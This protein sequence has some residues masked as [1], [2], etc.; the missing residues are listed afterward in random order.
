M[1]TFDWKKINDMAAKAA[2]GQA[3]TQQ[4][5]AA[6]VG[7]PGAAAPAAPAA[8]TSP[9]TPAAPTTPV[10]PPEQRVKD[11]LAAG[12]EFANQYIGD[13]SLGRLADPRAREAQDLLNKQHGRL[14]GLNSQEMLAAREQA[15]TN[16]KQNSANDMRRMS[17]LAGSAGVR[18]GAAAGLQA[19]VMRGA[20]NDRAGF[21]RQMIL[22]NVAQQNKAYD[23]YGQTLGNQQGVE[24]G[25]GKYNLEQGN[26]EK[27]GQLGTAFQY[28]GLIDSYGASDD[29]KAQGEKSIQL[30]KDYIDKLGQPAAEK[31]YQP[32]ELD[33]DEKQLVESASKAVETEV[34]RLTDA[35]NAKDGIQMADAAGKLRAAITEQVSAEFPNESE[36]KKRQIIEDR[37]K[38]AVSGTSGQKPPGTTIICTEA[39]RQGLI[40]RSQLRRMHLYR[41]RHMSD[42]Q[43]EAYLVWAT[44][45]VALMRKSRIA[46]VLVA[47]LLR[48]VILGATFVLKGRKP[49]LALRIFTG[50]NKLVAARTQ[51]DSDA[52]ISA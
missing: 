38:N 48:R 17:Q 47:A 8:P 3:P 28:G 14:Q 9:A 7:Q 29:A 43:Y 39:H 4:E 52:R 16:I 12:M 15:I 36:S 49:S 10:V 22:D 45:V 25:I 6:T 20:A 23:Q 5:Q 42:E 2:A 35:V 37:Y 18:G 41:A 26:R 21:E 46:S 44:P 27:L 40:T 33:D 24:L 1:P 31:P 11:H 30:A 50:L 51:G 34:K 13:G 32:N 19:Q